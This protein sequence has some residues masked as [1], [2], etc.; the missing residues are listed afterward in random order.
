MT[1]TSNNRVNSAQNRVNREENH[2]KLSSN[3]GLRKSAVNEEVVQFYG[4]IE[5]AINEKHNAQE[6]TLSS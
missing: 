2:P 3:S 1:L 6:P 4:D 5:N